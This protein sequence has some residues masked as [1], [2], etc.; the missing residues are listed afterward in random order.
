LRFEGGKPWDEIKQRLIVELAR[1]Y[2]GPAK[3]AWQIQVETRLKD[4]DV[5]TQADAQ[6][7]H[8][9]LY[10][11][12]GRRLVG[13]GP[14]VLTVHALAPYPGWAAMKP[15]IQEAVETVLAMLGDARVV[16]AAV[17]YVDRITL[18]EGAALEDYF[19][20]A[21]RWPAAMQ[22]QSEFSIQ[23]SSRDE[24]E[25]LST[26]VNFALKRTHLRPVVLYDVNLVAEH[27]HAPLNRSAWWPRLEDLHMRQRAYFED[28]IT[29]A[30]RRLFQ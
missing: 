7:L 21:P 15:R 9:Q 25:R 26:T 23:L 29:P 1:E 10:T 4:L 12:D 13:I 18:P 30:T 27:T 20:I 6:F 16:E 3:D 28:S 22:P 14:G 8:R 19:T 2:S 5:D 17:R 11:Q 24:T